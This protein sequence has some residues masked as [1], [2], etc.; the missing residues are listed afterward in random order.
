ML[1][2]INLRGLYAERIEQTIVLASVSLP[3][4]QA[5]PALG[6]KLRIHNGGINFDCFAISLAEL[7]GFPLF[8]LPV[9]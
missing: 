7:D 5:L 6:S 4:S 9:C 3:L 2:L 1:P 8:T